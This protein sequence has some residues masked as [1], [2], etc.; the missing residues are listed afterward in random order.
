MTKRRRHSR[1]EVAAKLD[2]AAA[3]AAEGRTQTEI[4]KE[5]GVSVMTF[6]RWRKAQPRRL[7]S[8][9]S[10]AAAKAPPAASESGNISSRIAQLQSENAR[11]RKLVTDLLLEKM[12]LEDE[13]QPA[14][15]QASVK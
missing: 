4:A 11:L 14:A 6:H 10:A 9:V 5:L 13:L 2:K 3:L 1:A 15:K 8:V 7:A 12:M